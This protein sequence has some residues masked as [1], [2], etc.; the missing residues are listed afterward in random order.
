[1]NLKNEMQ[2][3]YKVSEIQYYL[4]KFNTES[5]GFVATMG[6]LHDAHMS[7]IELSSKEN[8]ITVCSIFVNP[9]QF[10]RIQISP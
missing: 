4:T 6:A 3:F 1:M 10:I 5:V 7:L 2:I 9:K 8:R